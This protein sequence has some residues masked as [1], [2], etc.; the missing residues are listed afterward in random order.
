MSL[1]MAEGLVIDDLSGPFQPKPFY[2]SM[3][4]YLIAVASSSHKLD[5]L[6]RRALIW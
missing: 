1:L 6:R 2:D 4:L 3:I 5:R